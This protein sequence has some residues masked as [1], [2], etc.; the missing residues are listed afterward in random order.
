MHWRFGKGRQIQ[1]AE[2]LLGTAWQAIEQ[3]DYEIAHTLYEESLPLLRQADYP[4]GILNARF[5]LAYI[6]HK[7]N[8]YSTARI[9]YEQCINLSR[10][11]G[12]KAEQAEALLGLAMTVLLQGERELADRL[13]TEGRE[14]FRSLESANGIARNLLLRGTIFVDE[15]KA[16]HCYEQSL[17]MFRDLHDA[18]GIAAALCCLGF[19]AS[20][21]RDCSQERVYL[22]QCRELHET[23]GDKQGLSYA[24]N[25]LGNISRYE[26]D[27]AQASDLYRQS[28]RLKEEVGDQWAITYTLEG[29]AALAASLGDGE[30]SAR[31]FGAAESIRKR[32]GT[33][34]E[35]NKQSEYKENV[36]KARFLLSAETFLRCWE[37]GRN[38]SLSEAVADA[39][40]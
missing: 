16:R 17:Q 36:E 22:E 5:G 6:A 23:R 35:P 31:L 25:N 19:Q 27:F 20:P 11:L 2:Q 14:L 7:R 28:L 40:A 12:L 37:E 39:C 33:P 30:R 9:H 8:D 13:C 29:C 3:G 38:L 10:T 18:E 32:L 24:L 21:Y 34:L 4:T 26:G 1:R 15:E